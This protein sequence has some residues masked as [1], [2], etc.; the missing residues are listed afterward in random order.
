[1]A[2]REITDPTE[3]SV[4]VRETANDTIT[5]AQAGLAH[6]FLED[7]ENEMKT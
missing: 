3:A 1:M 2:E 5:Q 4:A 7:P 6:S